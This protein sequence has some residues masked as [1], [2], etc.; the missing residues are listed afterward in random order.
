MEEIERLV[1]QTHYLH[2]ERGILVQ[3]LALPGGGV[4]DTIAY[5]W[6][7]VASGSTAAAPV[8]LCERHHRLSLARRGLLATRH[9]PARARRRGRAARQA[10]RRA[11]DAR[12]RRAAHPAGSDSLRACARVGVQTSVRW[13]VCIAVPRPGATF[14]PTCGVITSPAR[15]CCKAGP[16]YTRRCPG[17]PTFSLLPVN[18]TFPLPTI[19]IHFFF[20]SSAV[21]ARIDG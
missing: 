15:S 5:R 12:H 16:S 6:H 14:S 1:G 2:D 7:D 4:C 17:F 11:L 10:V 21:A 19:L 20:F 8:D 13:R 18:G 9:V 3:G